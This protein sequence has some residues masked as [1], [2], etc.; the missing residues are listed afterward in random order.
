MGPMGP[1]G[2]SAYQIAKEKGYTD[3]E[4]KWLESLKATAT[5][6]S[7]CVKKSEL[8]GYVTTETFTELTTAFDALK[9]K[10][11]EAHPAG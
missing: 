4:E 1:A 7:D 11:E 2:K 8:T 3:T 5:D 9:K 6:I 10:V